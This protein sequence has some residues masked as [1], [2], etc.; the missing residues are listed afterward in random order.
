MMTVNFADGDRNGLKTTVRDVLNIVFRYIR[1]LT[2]FTLS[3]IVVIGIYGV[4]AKKIYKSNAKIL[5]RLGTEQSGTT[6]FVRDMDN[7]YVT[8]REQ[9]LKNEL[10][11]LTSDWVVTEVARQ[12]VRSREHFP[13]PQGIRRYIKNGLKWVKD[14]LGTSYA[15]EAALAEVKK[16]VRS[17]LEAEALFESDTLELSFTFPDP[18]VAQKILAIIVEQFLRHH[19]ETYNTNREL[20]FLELELANSRRDFEGGL[21]RLTRFSNEYGV[22]DEN[23]QLLLLMEKRDDIER[24]L[25]EVKA[26]FDYNNW[27]LSRMQGLKKDIEPF[28]TF[29]TVEVQNQSRQNLK[30]RLA[31]ANIE[32]QILLSSHKPDSRFIKGVED[33]ILLI[34]QLLDR[35]PAR[36]TDAIDSRKNPVY[37]RLMNNTLELQSEVAGQKAKIDATRQDLRNTNQELLSYSTNRKNYQLLHKQVELARQSYEKIFAGYLNTKLKNL[38]GRQGITNIAITE[39]P[40]QTS[41]PYRPK[42]LQLGAITVTLLVVG[43]IFLLLFFTMV[44]TTIIN[45][46]EIDRVFG[47]PPVGVVPIFRQPA[48]DDTAFLWLNQKEVIK[49]QNIYTNLFLTVDK[50]RV[51]ML[52]KSR[53]GEGGTTLSY[54]LAV[55]MAAYQDKQVALVDC[56][57][58]LPLS[59]EVGSAEKINAR[60]QK[61][62]TRGISIFKFLPDS[63]RNVQKIE[64]HFSI[65]EELKNTYDVVMVNMPPVADSPDMIFL[66]RYV[67][68]A[69]LVIEA[70]KT[71]WPIIRYNLSLLSEYGFANPSTVLNKRRY[72]IPQLVYRYL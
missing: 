36:V 63:A 31:D 61:I 62:D 58:D 72:H 71:R 23:R 8:R 13:K 55:F 26:D 50:N 5:I 32:K 60:Y 28:E 51:I 25:R 3:V 67:N 1:H 38:L 22:F 17:N 15:P 27:K 18:S 59:I 69:L 46:S 42:M 52:S 54:N 37:E 16:F 7:V 70:E 57:D 49:L 9:E 44:D 29:S 11:I 34:Q 21:E 6:P 48:N 10:E 14:L 2:W 53:P 41:T 45:P 24:S 65:L 40:S 35:E 66:Q 68:K 20:N 33:E 39:K 56:H 19:I 4:G 30:N 47:T 12:I 43:N 64:D